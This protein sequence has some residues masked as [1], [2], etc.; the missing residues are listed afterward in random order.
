MSISSDVDIP[1]E[2]ALRILLRQLLYE[3]EVI[4]RKALNSMTNDEL[5]C[6]LHSDTYFYHVSGKG[7]LKEAWEE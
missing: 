3:Q 5:A 6:R 1:R 4:I 7:K 2:K